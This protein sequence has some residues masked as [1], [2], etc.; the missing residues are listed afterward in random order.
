MEEKRN[1]YGL[2][3][4]PIR[5]QEKDII[6][7]TA[8]EIEEQLNSGGFVLSHNEALDLGLLN[9]HDAQDTVIVNIMEAQHEP[10]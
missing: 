1:K 8:K 10:K 4:A 7:L 2:F 3:D 6:S 5:T 9:T